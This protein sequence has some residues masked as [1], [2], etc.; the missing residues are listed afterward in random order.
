MAGR[1]VT[2]GGPELA[3]E[4]EESGY[5]GVAARLGI[6]ELSIERTVESKPGFDRAKTQ[7]I[8]DML[9]ERDPFADPLA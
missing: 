6:T 1:I 4:L 8:A 9:K 3:D 2:S 5:E 7:S